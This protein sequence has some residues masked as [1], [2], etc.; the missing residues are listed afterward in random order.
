MRIQNPENDCNIVN[1][2]KAVKNK[3]KKEMN[4]RVNPLVFRVSLNLY[5]VELANG[6]WT[7]W[8][9]PVLRSHQRWEIHLRCSNNQSSMRSLRDCLARMRMN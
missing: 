9:L 7:H 6:F 4:S 2:K 8:N 3:E 1:K 5:R